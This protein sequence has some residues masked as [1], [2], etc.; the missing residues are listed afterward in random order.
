MSNGREKQGND[1]EGPDD[2]ARDLAQS[3]QT[4]VSSTN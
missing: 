4:H 3:K 2:C 1:S